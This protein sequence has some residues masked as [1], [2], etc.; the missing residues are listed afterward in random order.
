[1]RFRLFFSLLLVLA[2]CSFS[3]PGRASDWTQWRGPSHLNVAAEGQAVPVSWDESTN[4]VWRA[5]IPGRGHASPIV[6]GDLVIL[7]TADEA[8]QT[9]AVVACERKTGRQLWLTPVSQGGFP[10][11]HQKNTHASSTAATDG[12]LIFATFCHHEKIEVVAL[13]FQGQVVWRTDAGKFRPQAYEY[14]YAASPT[15]YRN[16]LIVSADC[17]TG[18]WIKALNVKDGSTVWTTE[19]PLML[20]WGSPV[21]A[22]INGKEQMLLSGTNRIAAYDPASGA[23]LWNTPCLTMATCGTCIWENGLIFASGGYPDAETVAVRADGSGVAWKNKVKCYEQSMLISQGHVYAFSDQGIFYCW[24]AATGKE[25]WKQRLKGPV[26]A[27]PL[28]VG[29]TIFATNEAGTT[30]VI[31]ATP[32]KYELISQN[33]LGDSGFASMI[34]TDGQ[35]F[36]RTSKGDGPSR[37]E[38]LYCLGKP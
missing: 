20:N 35:L 36:V 28:L 23:A 26:S 14:G 33:Q 10:T 17:D 11:L 6:I 16:T 4:V 29:D 19:R 9:Q 32:E 18:A 7:C 2:M 25:M 37:Q 1:M 13:D 15:L 30:W 22:T 12:T 3:A 38:F 5:E 31:R 21:V 34:A 8:T 24:E 27:S